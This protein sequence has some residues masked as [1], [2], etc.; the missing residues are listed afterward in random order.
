MRVLHVIN[1]FTGGGA[2]K[3][4]HDTLLRQKA[5]GI[6]A[7]VFLL[8]RQ[9]NH[10]LDAIKS[11]GI[12]VYISK[13]KSL[14]SPS[15]IKEL[16]KVMDKGNFDVVHVHLFPALYWVA[17]ASMFVSNKSKLVYT[18]HS[19]H[20]RRRD[21]FHFKFIEAFI[22][23]HYKR[24]FCISEGT[25]QNLQQW[26]SHTSNKTQV[27]PNGINLRDY[28]DAKPYSKSDLF[29]GI[30]END[31]VIVMVARFIKQ[32][33]HETLIKCLNYLDDSYKLLF[34]GTGKR[35]EDIKALSRLKGVNDKVAFLGFREDIPQILK[36]ADIF[37]LS[38]HWE[39]FGLVAVEAMASGLPVLVSDVTGLRDVVGRQDM[40][41]PQGNSKKL[42]EKIN[43][44]ILNNEKSNELIT[45]GLER[46]K[47]FSIESMVSQ[48]EQEYKS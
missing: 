1:A 23:R 7:N 43:C 5:Q 15:H 32:K 16:K 10:Y 9:N 35:I 25:E 28:T 31:K 48:L 30:K 13:Y 18:E 39:G 44:I 22:Y 26:V 20:N 17:I 47:Q 41:F 12:Q 27:V 4:L 6:D 34:V 24:I 19:T 2:E 14:Y 11:A 3:L 45:Y 29:P 46:S 36:T 38:S 37:V 40:T 33:D 8:S 42:A 21:K